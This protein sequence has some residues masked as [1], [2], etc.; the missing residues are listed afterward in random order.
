MKKEFVLMQEPY[1]E[2]KDKKILYSTIGLTKLYP[3][4]GYSSCDE[5]GNTNYVV[6][7][8]LSTAKYAFLDDE[9]REAFKG[10]IVFDEKEGIYFAIVNFW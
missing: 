4:K 7:Y 2:S 9:S 6:S 10:E 3:N 1:I 8:A 5:F